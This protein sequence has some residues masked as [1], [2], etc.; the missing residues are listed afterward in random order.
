MNTINSEIQRLNDNDSRVRQL[1]VLAKLDDEEIRR[2]I[3]ALKHNTH[4]TSLNLA[5]TSHSNQRL[6]ALTQSRYLK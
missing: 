5:F 1:V 6:K 3:E 4:I 2:L